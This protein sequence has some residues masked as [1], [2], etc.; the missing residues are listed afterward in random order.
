MTKVAVIGVGQ[1]LRGD[2]AAGLVA[3]H[4]WREGY[5]ET[6]ARPEVRVETNELPG[7]ALLDLIEGAEAAVLVDAVQTSTAPGTIHL[8]D[9]E[10]LSAFASDAKS[11]HGWGVAETL[12]MGRLLGKIENT[13]IRLI[14]I[15][16]E[17]MTLGDGLSKT[18]Q[19]A[20]PLVCKLIQEEVEVL[21]N[22]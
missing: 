19:D 10:E 14:G 16:A 17:Q 1:S 3:V 13:S 20:I 22:K 4:Q 12:N 15:E 9:Q 8:L 5:P 7:L 2:D 18:V 11:A 6:A 21:I